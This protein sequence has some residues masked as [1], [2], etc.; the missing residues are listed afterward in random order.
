MVSISFHLPS[1]P[2]LPRGSQQR[3]SVSQPNWLIGGI[4]IVCHPTYLAFFDIVLREPAFS[5]PIVVLAF[6]FFWYSR[7]VHVT[8]FWYLNEL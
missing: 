1:P 6:F 5:A 7:H 8:V 4:E 3:S 2:P